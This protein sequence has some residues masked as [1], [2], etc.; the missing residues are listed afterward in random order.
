[1]RIPTHRPRP[2][3]TTASG[4]SLLE[5]LIV[6]VIIGIL[7]SLALPSYTKYIR[8]QGRAD[9][10]DL[11]QTNAARL[12]RCLTLAGAYNPTP[13]CNL[14]TVS[15]EGYYN[16]TSTLTAQTWSLEAVPNEY[17]QQSK[18]KTC[19]KLTMNHLGEK[20]ATGDYPEE[21]W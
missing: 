16:L 17:K 12:Q 9:A 5:L 3:H 13:K 6:I 1:M 2:N 15:P 10:H 7:T 4:F 19:T 8:Q 20:G 21:C 18:D 11:L 14:L